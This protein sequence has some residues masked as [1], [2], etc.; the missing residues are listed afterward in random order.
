MNKRT[1]SRPQPR[2]E[3]IPIELAISPSKVGGRGP[4]AHSS[5]TSRSR[6][7]QRRR[8]SRGAALSAALEDIPIGLYEARRGDGSSREP[9]DGEMLGYWNKETLL[10]TSATSL[11]VDPADRRR[12]SEQ[13][14]GEVRVHDLDVRL[15]RADGAVI[16]VRDTTHVKRAPDGTALLYEGALEDITDRVE[17]E[18][19]VQA[20]ERRFIQILEAA[21]VGIMVT[22]K[23]GARSFMNAAARGIF[24]KGVAEG[25]QSQ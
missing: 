1:R 22:D 9:G 8:S 3:G 13:K 19:A 17:A 20:S 6:I 14:P 4:S 23:K 11:Y 12:W 5:A 24:G 15:R 18:H 10:A 16:W 21:P 25:G 2:R 7:K